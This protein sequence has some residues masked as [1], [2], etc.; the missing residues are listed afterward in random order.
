MWIDSSVILERQAHSD[1]LGVFLPFFFPLFTGKPFQ[2]NVGGASVTGK[3]SE[4]LGWVCFDLE[5]WKRQL[6]AA[7]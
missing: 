6:S 3:M 2:E 5:P 1:Y 7:Q 4:I